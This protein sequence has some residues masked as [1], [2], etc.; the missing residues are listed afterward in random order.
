MGLIE[1]KLIAKKKKKKNRTRRNRGI[2]HVECYAIFVSL[3]SELYMKIRFWN[4]KSKYLKF[5]YSII[6]F[7]NTFWF[8]TFYPFSYSETSISFFVYPKL[9]TLIY[10]LFVLFF[11]VHN[12]HINTNMI[13]TN[14]PSRWSVKYIFSSYSWTMPAK[15]GL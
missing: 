9:T 12:Y 15:D 11:N 2:K 5:K 4:H 10:S 13:L 8:Y 7:F 3:F 14:R 1:I 6:A